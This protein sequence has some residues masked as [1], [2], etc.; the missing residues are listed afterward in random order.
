M[1]I[2]RIYVMARVYLNV[3]ISIL[4]IV[5][6]LMTSSIIRDFRYIYNIYIYT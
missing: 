1:L 2:F 5:V 3:I 4:I 6:L